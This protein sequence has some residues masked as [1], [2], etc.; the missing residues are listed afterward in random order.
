MSD[1]FNDLEEKFNLPYIIKQID[2]AIAI[3]QRAD[4]KIWM[5]NF[6]TLD[7]HKISY[8][9]TEKS[10]HS[11]GNRACFAGYIAISPEFIEDGGS[12]GYCGYPIFNGAEYENAIAEWLGISGY[13]S[14][15]LIYDEND[16][17]Y[18][19]EFEDI[20]SEDVILKLK[21]IKEIYIKKAKNLA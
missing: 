6:Q 21:D 17:F 3:M 9:T 13:Y 20:T 7:K 15:A 11:C 18:K 5:L 4:D 12:I 10:L 16:D 14:T 19:K 8:C 1:C 2:K